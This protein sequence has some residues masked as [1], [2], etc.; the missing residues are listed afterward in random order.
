ILES[1]LP[2]SAVAR[3]GL[4]LLGML[5]RES[6]EERPEDVQRI[7][8]AAEASGD[9]ALRADALLLQCSSELNRGRWRREPFDEAVALARLTADPDRIGWALG[10]LGTLHRLDGD[11]AGAVRRLHEA[12]TVAG[13]HGP[14]DRR[15]TL[16]TEL[17]LAQRAMFDLPG[18]IASLDAALPYAARA[19]DPF[20]EQALMHRLGGTLLYFGRVDPAR[21]WLARAL[22]V[23]E[24]AGM[25]T[26]CFEIRGSLAYLELERGDLAAAEAGMGRCLADLRLGK[27]FHHVVLHAQYALLAAEK[28]DLL[29][30]ASLASTAL[31][32]A[33]R[34]PGAPPQSL[35]HLAD[36]VWRAL[37]DDPG[38]SAAFTRACDAD[39]AGDQAAFALGYRALV[40][41]DGQQDLRELSRRSATT[42]FP[43]LRAFVD[44]VTG[45]TDD[46][47][48]LHARLAAKL[49]AA[50]AR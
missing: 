6:A 34:R 16:L 8:A 25:A 24:R 7:R 23:A 36:G 35:A 40:S 50:R 39:P 13:D 46:P 45:R 26:P 47:G 41:D 22:D 27:V 30:A 11:A 32:W 4:S 3:A 9:L 2:A 43:A 15:V 19:A 14:P 28:G 49:R 33:E 18:A 29:S 31:T 48:W 21:L 38:A 5:G 10:H 1:D 20:V 17:G 44:A 12:V 37:A 42:G